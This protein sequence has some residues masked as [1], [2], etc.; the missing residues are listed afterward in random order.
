MVPLIRH[1]HLSVP[2][3]ERNG[4][5]LFALVL[6]DEPDTAESMARLLR[7]LGH[8]VHAAPDGPSALRVARAEPPDVVVLDI[9]WPGMTSRKVARQLWEQSATRKPFLIAIT[10]EKQQSDRQRSHEAG[11]HLHLAKPVDPDFLCKVLRRFQAIIMPVESTE[12]G[13]QSKT[14]LSIDPARTDADRVATMTDDKLTCDSDPR[15]RT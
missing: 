1:N 7:Q 13:D 12:S 9:G 8:R 14:P 4:S 6:E 11:I 2:T 3:T 15:R 5:G 10:R